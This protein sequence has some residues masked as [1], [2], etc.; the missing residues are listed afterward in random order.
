MKSF[1]Q[2]QNHAARDHTDR[3]VARQ[4]MYNQKARIQKAKK[5]LAVLEEECG[6]LD[7]LDL[8]DMSCSTGIMTQLY[9]ERFAEVR[10]IDIDRQAVQYAQQN[11]TRSNLVFETMNALD[12]SFSAKSF[13]IIIC[14]QMYEHVT[15]ANLLLDE[16]FR[17]LKP[18]GI[19]YFG[20]TNRLKI[21]ETHYGKIPFLSVIPKP[22]ASICLR[23][24]GKAETY[25]ETHMSYWSLKRLVS[26]F[27]V[28]DYTSKVVG[29]PARYYATDIVRSGSY[30]QRV[31][32]IIL[33]FAYWLFPGYIW[34]LRKPPSSRSRLRD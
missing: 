14:N 16:I 26:R 7:Q 30:S 32:Q 34:L 22:L 15:D 3:P 17:L 4:T 33:R 29:D 18:G 9:A 27:Q 31:A 19:C 28:I 1:N 20:A 5:I 6:D 24:L 21:M 23:L 13:D 8:L 10:A 12:T 11:N 2:P 25:S